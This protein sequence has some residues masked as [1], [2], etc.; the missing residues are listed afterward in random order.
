[1][2]VRRGRAGMT[3]IEMMIALSILAV[4]TLVSLSALAAFI[5]RDRQIGMEVA[6]AR[7]IDEMVSEIDY[8]A[9][10]APAGEMPAH[11]I[12][13]YFQQGL[14][15]TALGA[16]LNA[17]PNRTA[18]PRV[19]WDAANSRYIYRFWVPAFG[20]ARLPETDPG[21]LA[22]HYATGEIYLYLDER[23]INADLVPRFAWAD[24]SGAP[25]GVSNVVDLDANGVYTNSFSPGNYADLKQLVVGIQV[26]YFVDEGHQRE[27]F[28]DS[29]TVVVTRI[30]DPTGR[31][32]P[33]IG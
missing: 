2:A 26:R 29:R 22:N 18:K 28:E 17:G 4:M 19:E 13:R 9:D 33:V 10:A 5:Q 16:N 25:I 3:L 21:F 11:Y 31:F 15:P 12:V 23:M 14:F 27:M 1:M 30:P 20:E 24:L 6:T 32:D 7:A 8:I